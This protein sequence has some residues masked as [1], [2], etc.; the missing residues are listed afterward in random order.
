M[1]YIN[2]KKQIIELLNTYGG[3]CTIDT[4]CKKL[5][6][7]KSTVRRDLIALEEEGI[8]N[9]YHGGISLAKDSASEN[10]ASMRKMKNIEKKFIISKTAKKYIHDNMVLFLDSSSTTSYLIPY[11]KQCKNITIITNGLNVANQL[12]TASDLKLY[13][14]PGILKHKSFSIVG[15]YSSEFLNNFFAQAVFFSCKAINVNGI[16]EGDDSQALNKRAMMKNANKKILLCDNTKEFSS[17][18]FKLASLSEIDIIISNAL[19]SDELMNV[20]NKNNVEF[21]YSQNTNFNISKES[22]L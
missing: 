10:P 22:I 11:I 20:I 8:I 6:S 14:C 17:G 7:S 9:R 2:R 4:I 13:L 5:Y 15:E 12:N 21:V 18:Y 1:A 19:F 3:I 16:F